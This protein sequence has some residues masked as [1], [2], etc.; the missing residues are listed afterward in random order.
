VKW[1]WLLL[2]GVVAA[3]GEDELARRVVVLA[4]ASDPESV[5]LARY[6][7]DKRGIP[8]ENVVSL[9]MPKEETIGWKEFVPSIWQPLQD[10]LV[11]RH[12]ID[13]IQM[14]LLDPIGRKKYAIYGHRIAYLVVC[15]GVPLRI[16]HDP[17][18]YADVPPLTSRVEFRTNRA[19]V[20]GELALLAQTTP[21]INAFVTNP[22][23][24]NDHPSGFERSQVVKVARLDGPDDASA[25]ALVDHALE[26]ERNGLLGR[27]YVDLGGIHPD[28][29]RWLES[30]AGELQRLNFE[31]EVD[32]EPKTIP[33]TARMDAPA[34]YFGWYAADLNGPMALPGFRF[35][36]GAIA[37]HIHSYSART[38]H[39]SS[40]GWC[41]PLVARGAT[42]T[43][44]NVF[45]PYLQITHAP[46]LL[47]RALVR[48][49]N[50]GDAAC[51]ALPELG[52]QCVLIGDPL[53]RPF[54]VS[55]DAQLQRLS[56]L[57]PRLS[58][59]AVLRKVQLLDAAGKKADAVALLRQSQAERPTLAAG[60]A[61]SLRLED[62]GDWA[63]AAD[64]LRFAARLKTFPADEWAL[65][66]KIA[67]RLESN[68]A[69]AEA[70]AVY[71]HLLSIEAQ[72]AEFRIPCLRDARE[73]ALRAN[74][75]AQA[76]RWLQELD[77][78]LV[79]G[80]AGHPP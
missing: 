27:A 70:L 19:A 52:W 44:G 7:A 37:F 21:P 53:Y 78:L 54:A 3:R 6:Y 80:S 47:V 79:T 58:A 64:V 28:G 30:V 67:E 33:A 10:E 31:L 14:S 71:Q 36:P 39:S 8:A 22:L 42:A 72:P 43:L 60:L 9:A 59:Y 51:Y 13:A 34:L 46:H 18:L 73:A 11:R 65:A 66:W 55:L 25:R 15:R 24:R 57:P 35:P 40:E 17:S 56:E 61:L 49:D 41:G 29:D 74:D 16:E 50:L 4:N 32:R 23:Y 5:R 75:A 63:G 48:G 62:A 2:V 68:A 77:A 69:A 12:W 20:D 45:E 1:L 26:A 76:A 38:L